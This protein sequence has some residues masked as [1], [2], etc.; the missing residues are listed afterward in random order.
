MYSHIEDKDRRTYL[1]MVTALDDA[2]GE[3]ITALKD[4][5]HYNNSV[6]VFTTDVSRQIF[7]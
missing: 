4:T 5:G 2:V 6:I 3:I 7:F 1:G